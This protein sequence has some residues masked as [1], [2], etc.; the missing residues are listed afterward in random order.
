MINIVNSH[1]QSGQEMFSDAG[2]IL[3]VN[4]DRKPSSRMSLAS[5]IGLIV[6][7]IVGLGLTMAFIAVLVAVM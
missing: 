5:T 3:V 7:L 1:L 4:G 6:G 2:F